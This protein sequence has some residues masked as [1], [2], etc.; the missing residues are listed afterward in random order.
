MSQL[1]R[2]YD[3]VEK[4]LCNHIKATGWWGL[5]DDTDMHE[6]ADILTNR[7]RVPEGIA[8]EL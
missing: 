2:Q 3:L 4:P 7:V 5:E 6:V 8:A 1:R